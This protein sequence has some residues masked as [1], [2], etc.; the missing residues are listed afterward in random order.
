MACTIKANYG[1]IVYKS[2][3][4]K[5]NSSHVNLPYKKTNKSISYRCVQ[6]TY[7]T[8]SQWCTNI[9]IALSNTWN[10]TYWSY[11]SVILM[12]N[13]LQMCINMKLQQNLMNMQNS[14]TSHTELQSYKNV[15]SILFLYD[16]FSLHERHVRLNAFPIRNV[17]S[18]LTTGYAFPFFM[19]L[20]MNSGAFGFNLLEKTWELQKK[21]EIFNNQL[22][23]TFLN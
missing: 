20:G 14:N 21:E 2:Q 13:L 3:Y 10:K 6:N 5:D 9:H 7:L 19:F 23:T 17:S 1:L 4:K 15:G 16:F 11:F 18:P 22:K 12:E 8:Q